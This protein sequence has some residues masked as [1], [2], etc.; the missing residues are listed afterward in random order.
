[1]IFRIAVIG[2]EMARRKEWRGIARFS[3]ITMVSTQKFAEQKVSS[4]GNQAN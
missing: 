3:V 2:T 4:N 1:M